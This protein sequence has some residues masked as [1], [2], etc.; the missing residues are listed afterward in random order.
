MSERRVSSRQY[1]PSLTYRRQTLF[2]EIA[3]LRTKLAKLDTKIS[4]LNERATLA[5]NTIN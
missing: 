3:Q 5:S 1:Q 4:R 2:R